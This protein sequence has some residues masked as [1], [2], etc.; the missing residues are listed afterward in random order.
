MLCQIS[1]YNRMQWVN[2]S[3]WN[4]VEYKYEMEK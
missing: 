2:I 3:F 4:V 1:N